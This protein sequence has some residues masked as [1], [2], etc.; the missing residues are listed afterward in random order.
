MEY[1]KSYIIS[2]SNDLFEKDLDDD[3]K[4]G[5]LSSDDLNYY[6][7]A[8]KE[9][10]RNDLIKIIETRINRFNRQSTAN[11]HSRSRSRSRSRSLSR[12]RSRSRSRRR[13][14]SRSHSGSPTTARAPRYGGR[15]IH[16][17]RTAKN[18]H[19]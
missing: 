6:L 13:R 12:S 1:S 16:K 15:S 4:K 19:R 3:L 8:A 9:L 7:Q 11:V 18:K 14:S 17:R 5:A 2:M 10:G